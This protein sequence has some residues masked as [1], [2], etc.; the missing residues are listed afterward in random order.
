LIRPSRRDD[1]DDL[2]HFINALVDEDAPILLNK[3]ATREEESVWLD[4]QL[5]SLQ[6]A[7]AQLR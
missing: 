3:K 4:E 1:L 2:L 6:K 7:N 5:D